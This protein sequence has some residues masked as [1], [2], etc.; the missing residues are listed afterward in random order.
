[1]YG[2]AGGLSEHGIPFSEKALW[3][4]LTI[5]EVLL[6]FTNYLFCHFDVDIIYQISI[7]IYI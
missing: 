1:M 6:R 2:R 3:V 7:N 4:F 5:A